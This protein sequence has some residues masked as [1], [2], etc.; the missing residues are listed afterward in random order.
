MGKSVLKLKTRRDERMMILSPRLVAPMAVLSVC[1][2]LMFTSCGG[3]TEEVNDDDIIVEMVDTCL[4]LSEVERRIPTGLSPNDSAAL[5]DRIVGNWVEE[6]VISELAKDRLGDLSDIDRKV[7]DYRRRLIVSRYVAQMRRAY[8]PSHGEDSIRAFYDQ[9]RGEMLSETP[10]VKGLLVK[11]PVQLSSLP[12]I[13]RCLSAGDEVAI[14][15]LEREWISD[16][17]QYEYFASTWVDWQRIADQIPYRFKDADEFV[18]D[19]PMF[20]TTS[21]GSV[22]LLRILDRLPS[23]SELPYEFAAPRIRAML[24][25]KGTMHHERELIGNL[26]TEATKKGRLKGVGYDPASKKIFLKKIHL[27]EE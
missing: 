8:E 13:R 11:A 20:E 6:M 7:E 15:E 14:D 2:V 19:L 24:D 16:A 4:R 5:F 1:L 17:L 22:Y 21:G 9:H 10:L 26:I 23:G 27:P 18:E 3:K 25:Q 12:E